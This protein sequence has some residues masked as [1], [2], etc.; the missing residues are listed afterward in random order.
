MVNHPRPLKD[1]QWLIEHIDDPSLRIVDASWNMPASGR[2]GYA[3]YLQRHIPNALFFDIDEHSAISE[4]PHMLPSTVEFADAMGKL[5][6]SAADNIIVYDSAGLFS[7]ARA[8]WMFQFFGAQNV[9]I[10]DGGLPAY[11]D[12]GGKTQS[13]LF[14][15]PPCKF[16]PG[17]S[18]GKVVDAQDVLQASNSGKTLILDARSHERFTAEVPEPRAGLRSGHIPG[19]HSLPFTEL[20]NN[21]K[22]KS[23]EN[24]KHVFDAYGIT[25]DTSFITTCGS[26]VTAAIIALALQCIGKEDVA[27]Y[28]GSWSE[29]GAR[30]DLPVQQG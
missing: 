23:E 13:G 12:A 19:S 4:L 26:G 29:W 6:I 16:E 2:N 24:L 1:A 10:L 21:G 5:G 27:L 14:E 17:Y 9:A 25:D 22:M 18:V 28:D 8:W 15:H 20:L 3:E 11:R 30:D 7:A